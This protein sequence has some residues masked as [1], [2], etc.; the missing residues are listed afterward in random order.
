LGKDDRLEK[1]SRWDCWGG[2][3]HDEK[4]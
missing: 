1:V 4:L 3:I 2:V